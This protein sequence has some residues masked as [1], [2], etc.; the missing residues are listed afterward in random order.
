M[1]P[2]IQGAEAKMKRFGLVLLLVL[3]LVGTASAARRYE[4]ILLDPL[5]DYVYS[6]ANAINNYGEIVGFSKDL[7]GHTRATY[8]DPG[9]N[10]APVDIG[11]LNYLDTSEAVGIN[12]SG[13]VVG[14]AYDH[15]GAG[16]HLAFI[17]SKTRP[18]Q[19]LQG[20]PGSTWDV[21]AGIASNGK[22]SGQSNYM[23]CIFERGKPAN[24]I[25]F[26]YLNSAV[27]FSNSGLVAGT[28]NSARTDRTIKA[29]VGQGDFKEIT[30]LTQ[31]YIYSIPNAINKNGVV[32]G[33]FNSSGNE[34][35]FL[36]DG[37]LHDLD[38]LG[39]TLS[40]ALAIN[41]SRQ[42]VGWSYTANGLTSAFFYQQGQGMSDLNKKDVVGKPD[43]LRFEEAHGINNQGDIVGNSN[44]ALAFLLRPRVIDI[45]TF[46]MLLL[47]D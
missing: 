16:G 17:W 23:A 2:E 9:K 30:P 15:T 43:Q 25:S 12:D 33:S 44:P 24:D 4:L 14:R 6:Y 38:T 3:G 32:I 7:Q 20:L 11:T 39:G 42:V 10:Y 41:D 5:E 36:W 29:V 18:I 34:H 47:F 21:A 22:V 46:I 31:G 8:W 45:G 1:N 37:S 13:E 26:G 35:A 28:E 19:Q 40:S 27:G